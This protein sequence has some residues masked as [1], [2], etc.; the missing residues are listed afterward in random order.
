MFFELALLALLVGGCA[1]YYLSQ[2]GRLEAEAHAL[3]RGA[4]LMGEQGECLFDGALAEVLEAEASHGGTD[5]TGPW[6]AVRSR[7]RM[8][9][10]AVFEVS[11]KTATRQGMAQVSVRHLP[12]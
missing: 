4:R 2:R 11:V 9:S 3:R 1:W 10:G 7:C 12:D 8:P 5:Q 6:L